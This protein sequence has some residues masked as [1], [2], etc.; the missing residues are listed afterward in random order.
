MESIN[1]RIAW[2]VKDMRANKNR[3][4]SSYKYLTIIYFKVSIWRKAPK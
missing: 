3:F 2:C 4:C 1:N